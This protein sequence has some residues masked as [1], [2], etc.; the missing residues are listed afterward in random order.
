MPAAATTDEHRVIV[1][2]WLRRA[3]N[4]IRVMHLDDDERRLV[5]REL[6]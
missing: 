1:D 4:G 5:V 6:F 2:R 3:I